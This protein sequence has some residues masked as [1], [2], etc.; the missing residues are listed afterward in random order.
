MHKIQASLLLI[1][2]LT[3]PLFKSIGSQ[4]SGEA[5]TDPYHVVNDG[6]REYEGMKLIWHDEFNN[7]GKPN[8]NNW[9]Y[10]YGFVR[11]NELQWYQ[12]QNANC[13]KGRLL[14][15]GRREKIIN[16]NYNPQSDNWRIN[17]QYAEYSSACLITRGNQE[18]KGGG[19]YEIRARIDSSMGSWPAIWLLGSKGRW[20]HG[21][22]ID[23]MEF[24][25]PDRKPAILANAAWGSEKAYTGEWDT[26]IVPLEHFL[27]KDPRWVEKYHVWSLHWDAQTMRIAIDGEII[28]EIDLTK[29]L[30]PD[31]HNP[32]GMDESF[33]LLLNLALGSNGGNPTNTQF[34]L[35]FEVDYVRVYGIE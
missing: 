19:Y 8:A 29:T 26:A 31:G 33:Y 20:P 12:T 3:M 22:E 34:P 11:N 17:R 13:T 18:W 24:Y 4:N 15:E 30:N 32:F 2:L 10:E 27:D 23:I 35:S 14:I 7:E 28:N 21:G 25:R 9:A 6:P 5:E 16:P 1:S